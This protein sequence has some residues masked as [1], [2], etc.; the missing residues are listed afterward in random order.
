MNITDFFKADTEVLKLTAYWETSQLRHV[1]HYALAGGKNSRLSQ[2]LENAGRV[3]IIAG[4]DLSA[5]PSSVAQ[6]TGTDLSARGSLVDPLWHLQTES[7]AMFYTL[8]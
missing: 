8:N 2:L 1:S 5:R 7:I 6:K 4:T 3:I